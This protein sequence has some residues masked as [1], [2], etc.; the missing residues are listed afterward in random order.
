MKIKYKKYM[1][2]NHKDI[3]LSKYIS[4]KSIIFVIKW[5]NF[6]YLMNLM[7]DLLLYKT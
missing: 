4:D 5:L 1:V 7:L 3:S 6:D 2:Y